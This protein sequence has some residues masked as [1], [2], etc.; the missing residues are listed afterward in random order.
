MIAGTHALRKLDARS[1]PKASLIL[2]GL[3]DSTDR[4]KMLKGGTSFAGVLEKTLSPKRLEA[5]G[6]PVV[7]NKKYSLPSKS[8]E[9]EAKANNYKWSLLNKFEKS[10]EDI[11]SA[12][13]RIMAK[14]P[15]L[16]LSPR[17]SMVVRNSS[18]EM[19][20]RKIQISAARKFNHVEDPAMKELLLNCHVLSLRDQQRRKLE[21]KLEEVNE[22]KLQLQLQEFEKKLGTHKSLEGLKSVRRK[23]LPNVV[24][25]WHGNQKSL[26]PESETNKEKGSRMS[27]EPTHSKDYSVKRQIKE[28][29]SPKNLII[30]LPTKEDLSSEDSPPQ[31]NQSPRKL[32]KVDPTKATNPNIKHRNYSL[33]KLFDKNPVEKAKVINSKLEVRRLGAN[34][35][36]IRDVE[37][38]KLRKIVKNCVRSKKTDDQFI[39]GLCQ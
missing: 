24:F 29:D 19:T 30:D 39:Q 23:H 32:A 36:Q 27:T 20:E 37:Q 26:Y 34:R 13:A 22:V 5:S 4:I 18:R 17:D 35:Y 21:R 6:S 2:Q 1:Q 16:I 7:I 25:R 9:L 28:F 11:T 8:E 3:K 12:N 31:E 38:E 10:C 15:L 33:V 14:Q